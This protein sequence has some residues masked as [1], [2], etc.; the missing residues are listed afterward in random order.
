MQIFDKSEQ[1]S[2]NWEIKAIFVIPKTIAV[3]PFPYNFLVSYSWSLKLFCE[4]SLIPKTPNRASKIE[5]DRRL[6]NLDRL[7]VGKI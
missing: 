6:A 4:L 1:T 7:S 3:I 5:P 2:E